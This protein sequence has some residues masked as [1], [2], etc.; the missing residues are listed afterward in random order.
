MRATIERLTDWQFV[1][2]VDGAQGAAIAREVRPD[3]ILLDVMM[4]E[5]DGPS[6]IRK[7]RSD[8]VTAD[9]PVIFITASVQEDELRPQRELG[10]TDIIM[11][12]FDP[13]ALPERIASALSW[14]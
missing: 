12:P 1:E 9:T 7:L 8:P 5:L 14:D 2:A 4:P 13:M 3:V 6:T 10:A 11:K